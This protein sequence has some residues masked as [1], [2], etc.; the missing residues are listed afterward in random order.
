MS[1]SGPPDPLWPP[2][3]AEARLADHEVHVWRVSLDPAENSTCPYAGLPYAEVLS[4]EERTRADRCRLDLERARF[5]AARSALRTV[6]SRYT[7][8]S[9]ADIR[10]G[11]SPRGRP[12]LLERPAGGGVDVNLSHSGRSALI[13]VT[14]EGRVGVDLEEIRTDVDHRAMARRFFSPAEAELIG[15]LPEAAGRRAFFTRWTWRE[16]YAKAADVAVPRLLDGA[17]LARMPI[18]VGFWKLRTLPVGRDYRA[19]VAAAGACGPPRCWMLTQH[20]PVDR[21]SPR[22]FP[23]SGS[24]RKESRPDA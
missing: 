22:N 12:F 2:G 21:T 5:M 7:G 19:T 24:G 23:R 15:N 3:P 9:P 4:P 20:L 11:R 1:R 16:A 8:Q 14:R 13:A 6:L 18:S 17:D 10:L